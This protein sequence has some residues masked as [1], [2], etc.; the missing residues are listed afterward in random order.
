MSALPHSLRFALLVSLFMALATAGWS[1]SA[2]DVNQVTSL[3]TR[4]EA[5]LQL[6][7]SSVGHLT[8][9]PKGSAAKLNRVRLDQA[10]VD[11]EAAGKLVAGLKNDA[12]VAEAK[13]RF[14]A[15]ETLYKKLDGIL[16]GLPP[17]PAPQPAPNP[18]PAPEPV[19]DKDKPVTPAP[20]APPTVKLGYPHADNFKSA[21]F[22][23]ERVE[24][25]AEH[26][27]KLMAEL[28]PV[29]DQLSLDHRV[30]NSA[31][32]K[33]AET[34]R[35][36]GF[37]RDGLTKIPANGEGVAEAWQRLADANAIVA[38][39]AAYF[40]PLQ[41]QLMALIDPAR[42]PELG[43][44]LERVRELGRAFG[45]P[46]AL[47]QTRRAAA[48]E[49]YTQRDAAFAERQRIATAYNRLIEQKTEHGNSVQSACT[50]FDGQLQAFMTLAT[51]Q[52]TALPAEL[53]HDLAQV[54]RMGDEAVADQ[55]PM[56]FT[57]GIP[58]QLATIDE[59]LALYAALDPEGSAVS[60][61][62]VESMRRRLAERA[63]SLEALIIL[64]NPLPNDRY[65]GADRDAAI[66][67]AV[68][69]WGFQEQGFELLAARIPGESWSRETKWAYSNG[70]WY[71]VDVSSLQVQLIVA[72]K[73]NAAQAI[74]RPINLRKDHQKGAKLIGLPMRSFDEALQP[75]EYLL[76]SKIK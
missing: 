30:T 31:L 38:N 27:T 41:A 1:K 21:V 32:S 9:P 10:R 73:A 7:D 17:T 62:A 57:G 42:Y 51:A 26:L 33:A 50:H 12:G 56:W 53:Q 75:N 5:N 24:R 4:A 18:A 34:R 13:A 67:V 3:L 49:V 46:V 20:T 47:F 14:A 72:D 35:Q 39:A 70:T 6:V 19:P 71:F 63:K 52:R 40:E 36:A 29:A 16:T 45:D 15:D 28:R 54:D 22:N 60:A 8:A 76:R 37:V 74:V 44:D 66:A 11:L 69:A 23:L 2:L 68:D 55:K 43:R 61:Q 59:K 58:E 65:A 48:I 25:E 64:E